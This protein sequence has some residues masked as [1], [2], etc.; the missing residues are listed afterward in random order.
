M[1]QTA[2]QASKPERAKEC[3]QPARK[4]ALRFANVEDFGNFCV[5][6]TNECVPFGYAGFHTVTLD[7]SDLKGESKHLVE[8]YIK[9]GSVE[10]F[11]ATPE[12]PRRV[13]IPRIRG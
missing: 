1:S 4:T 6:L 7:D 3:K 11:E 10:R 8:S 13:I 9:G 2:S 5:R 12:K